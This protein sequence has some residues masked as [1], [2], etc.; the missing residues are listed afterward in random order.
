MRA[1]AQFTDPGDAT[2]SIVLTGSLKEFEELRVAI[3]ASEIPFY[4]VQALLDQIGDAS[5]QLRAKVEAP[6]P[7]LNQ[8]CES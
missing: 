2:V 6:R 1:T 5:R 3:G 4:R 8:D 7:D